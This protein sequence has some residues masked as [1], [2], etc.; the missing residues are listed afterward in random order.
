MNDFMN[1]SI[2]HESSITDGDIEEPG[3]LE[4]GQPPATQVAP[5][6]L[7][8]RRLILT[9]SL[10]AV[11][12]LALTKVGLGQNNGLNRI[13]GGPRT[14]APAGYQGLA[15]DGKSSSQGDP[16]CG[17][18]NESGQLDFDEFFQE[19]AVLAKAAYS[20]PGLNEDA[21]LYR[22]AAVAA[23]LQRNTVPEAKTGVFAGLNPPVRFG[24]VRVAPPLA[25]ILW[26]LDPG[27]VLPPHNH[28]PADVLS[29]CLAGEA[30]VRHFDIVGHA[31][32]YSSKKPFLVRESRNIV[33]T[34][35]RMSGL[36]QTHDNIH[37]FR[38]GDQGAVGIDINT[39]LP[40]KKD[41]SFLEFSDKPV[42]PEK[43]VFEATWTKLG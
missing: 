15:I 28:T 22:I 9:G 14:A 24:P 10:A 42:D 21:H 6:V 23:R 34:A 18:A 27:A 3:H 20:D 8:A 25:M 11:A 36:T 31:P 40:G 29:V 26:R 1:K 43:R 5:G 41:F 2:W 12:A 30:R 39:V 13:S 16:L 37:T 19:C 17:G 38:A 35:G 7:E 33:L 32:D 4:N